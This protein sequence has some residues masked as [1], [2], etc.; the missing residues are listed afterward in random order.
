M[1]RAPP[2]PAPAPAAPGAAEQLRRKALDAPEGPSSF[3]GVAPSASVRGGDDGGASRALLALLVLP[4]LAL[5][6]AALSPAVL[7]ATPPTRALV[8][9]RGQ[10][11]FTGLTVLAAALVGILVALASSSI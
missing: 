1:H 10:I 2:R 8:E 9:H 3:L 4:V 7:S 5:A 11:A 6:L